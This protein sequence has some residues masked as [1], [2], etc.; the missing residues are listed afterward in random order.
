MCSESLLLSLSFYS[1]DTEIFANR[2]SLYQN[3][4]SQPVY[5]KASTAASEWPPPVLIL[6]ALFPSQKYAKRCFKLQAIEF[7]MSMVKKSTVKES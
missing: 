5:S 4:Q 3:G 7:G 2:P 1:D 6:P